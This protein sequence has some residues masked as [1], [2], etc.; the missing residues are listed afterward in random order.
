M[1]KRKWTGFDLILVLLMAFIVVITL[2][3]FLNILA[4]SLNNAV[5]TA[6]G[7][8]HIWP[9]DFTFA[10]YQEIFGSND[11]LL[12]AFFM[13]ILRTVVGTITGIIASTMLAYVLSRRDF[14]LNGFVGFLLVLTMFISGGLIPEYMLIRELGLINEFGVYIWPMLISAFN[15]II[16]RSFMDNLP[17]A[18]EESAKMDGANDFII[19]SRI[20]IPLCLPVIATIALFLAV[21]QWNSWFDTYLYARNNQALTTLQFE[22]MKILDNANI[23]SGDI[24]SQNAD[25]IAGQTNPQSIKMAI[26][27]IATVPILLVYPFLQK[28]FVTGLTLGAVKS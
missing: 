18:L 23:S 12:Q 20:I 21:M 16:I 2:Y 27:I 22:L 19:F 13:S 28:Y 3:P 26:T 4:I 11:L 10:N 5:D 9:R 1:K 17:A 6:R 24:T 14:V 25:V 8:I 7:G 15:V